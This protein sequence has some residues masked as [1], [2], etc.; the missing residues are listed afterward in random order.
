MGES[1]TQETS[2]GLKEF[3]LARTELT[4]EF[5]AVVHAVVHSDSHRIETALSAVFLGRCEPPEA[6][7]P[8]LDLEA[9]EAVLDLQAVEPR[10]LDPKAAKAGG[11]LEPRRDIMDPRREFEL[12]LK[13][14]RR[15]S[16]EFTMTLAVESRFWSHP[17]SRQPGTTEAR[18]DLKS[19]VRL[20]LIPLWT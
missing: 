16:A 12:T 2:V 15:D 9:V 1:S 14:P 4:H 18:L 20:K 19:V 11:P 5:A 8:V 7:D 3:L 10:L 13:E 6:L 17:L